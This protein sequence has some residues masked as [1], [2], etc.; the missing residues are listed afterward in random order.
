MK[1]SAGEHGPAGLV[2]AL[3]ASSRTYAVAVG[4]GMQ[5]AAQ[6]AAHRDDPAFT[7]LGELVRL[8]LS[9]AGA[10]F[11]DIGTIGV[12]VGPGGL[13]S[14]R[15]A[16]AYANGLAFALGTKIFPVSSLELMA[17]AA[18][19][20]HRGPLLCL[21]RGQGGNAYAGLFTDGERADLRHGPPG[22]VV[23]AMVSGLAAIHVA[24]ASA[25]EVAGL[26]AG[27]SVADSGVAEADVRVLYQAARAA[28]A[29]PER[30]VP[31]ATPLNEASEIFHEP[32]A[33]AAEG[34]IQ[35]RR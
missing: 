21:K 1:P 3:E 11:A 35:S 14:I 28:A 19:Q 32:A 9:R 12:D 8:A 20:A 23:P 10:A 33:G 7:E 26:L 24:G 34:T 6:A 15:A 29:E 13:S 5:P 30:L 2:L 17:M 25:D 16:V 22:S 31:A 4:A 18:R 27:V